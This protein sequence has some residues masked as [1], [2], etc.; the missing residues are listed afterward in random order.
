[1]LRVKI[2][3]SVG[4]F[5]LCPAVV[6][7]GI[8]FDSVINDVLPEVVMVE[9][10]VTDELEESR[11]WLVTNNSDSSPQHLAAALSTVMLL[12]PTEVL[13]TTTSS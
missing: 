9:I 13:C 10:F 2:P 8:L 12:T 3:T 1:M 7:F 6:T 5:A 4:K 11:V